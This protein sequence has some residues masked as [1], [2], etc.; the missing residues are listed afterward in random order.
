MRRSSPVL[1]GDGASLAP[2]SKAG[3]PENG[4]TPVSSFH[5]CSALLCPGQDW[6]NGPSVGSPISLSLGFTL[7]ESDQSCLVLVGLVPRLR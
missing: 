7:V 4:R 5:P 3:S 6:M 1:A 2:P